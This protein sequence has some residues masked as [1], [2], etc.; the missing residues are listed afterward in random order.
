MGKHNA[1]YP[2]DPTCVKVNI[3]K[4]KAGAKYWFDGLE[5]DS[6]EDEDFDE[7]EFEQNFVLGIE[8][9]FQNDQIKAHSSSKHAH[10]CC[11]AER[12]IV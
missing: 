1:V 2:T 4:P 7:P 6:S 12:K 5:D 11:G 10:T 9:D 3:C 8:S